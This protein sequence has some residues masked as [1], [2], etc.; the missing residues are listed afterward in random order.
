MPG[1]EVSKDMLQCYSILTCLRIFVRFVSY[2]LSTY[3][4]HMIWMD[5][6]LEIKMKPQNY[7]CLAYQF[8]IRKQKQVTSMLRFLTTIKIK[9]LLQSQTGG[10][11][12]GRIFALCFFSYCTW[13]PQS[14]PNQVY[15][16]LARSEIKYLIIF[17]PS[18][19]MI[20]I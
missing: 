13:L 7:C 5:L 2:E 15:C 19:H 10:R 14:R 6:A 17:Y 12:Y 4:I 11:E 1:I 16:L 18:N 8:I 9:Y 20:G 3:W